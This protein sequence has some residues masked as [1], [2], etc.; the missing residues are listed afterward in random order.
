MNL[1][2]DNVRELMLGFHS[3]MLMISEL[4]SLWLAQHIS[5]LHQMLQQP[6]EM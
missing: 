2:E 5:A 4:A 1:L 3:F 6:L